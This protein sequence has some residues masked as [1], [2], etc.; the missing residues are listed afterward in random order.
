MKPGKLR[1]DLLFH[2]NEK[3]F[4]K[5]MVKIELKTVKI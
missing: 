4:M 1:F 2:K 3:S 5:I